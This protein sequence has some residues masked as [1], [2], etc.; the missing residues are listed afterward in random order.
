MRINIG[1]KQDAI[2]AFGAGMQNVVQHPRPVPK[3]DVTSRT[4]RGMELAS[5]PRLDTMSVMAMRGKLGTSVE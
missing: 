4:L 2:P 5:R 1:T 3:L